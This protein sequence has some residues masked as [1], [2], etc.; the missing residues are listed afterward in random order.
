MLSVKCAAWDFSASHRG[1]SDMSQRD[2]SS[3]PK[4]AQEGLEDDPP[5]TAFITRNISK[6]DYV[7]RAELYMSK[8]CTKIMWPSAFAIFSTVVKQ[9]PPLTRGKK[10]TTIRVTTCISMYNIYIKMF[11]NP[12]YI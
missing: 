12:R 2:K 6:A 9:T 3:R 5:M 11:R 4:R 10:N 8:L 7:T 1:K